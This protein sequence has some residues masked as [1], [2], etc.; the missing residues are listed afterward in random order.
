M[1]NSWISEI[2]PDLN[3]SLVCYRDLSLQN[4]NKMTSIQEFAIISTSI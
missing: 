4:T 1:E 3:F 2:F